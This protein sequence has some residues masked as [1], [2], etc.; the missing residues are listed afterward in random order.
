MRAV[1]VFCEGS[2]DVTFTQRSL[3]AIAQ[4][5]WVS[6]PIRDLPSPFGV[7]TVGRGLIVSQFERVFGDL[8]L[9]SAAYPPLPSFEAIV[10]DP[11]SKTMFML[12]RTNGKDQVDPV[13]NILKYL[14]DIFDDMDIDTY[15]V[16]EYAAAFLFDANAIGRTETI[17]DFRRRYTPHFDNLSGVDHGT[18]VTTDV[19]PVGCFVFHRGIFDQTGTL[20][21]HLAPMAN[22][23]WPDRYARA[24]DF[25]HNN[26]QDSEV[27][28]NGASQ[29]KAVITAAGQF[30]VPGAG[31]TQVIGRGGLSKKVF[32]DSPLS[33]EL[34]DFLM[35]TPWAR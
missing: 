24:R 35:A 13:Q 20:E 6:K 21:D 15:D 23:E 14:Y 4:C 22:A 29:L 19:A 16:T 30:C 33:K 9:Q 17:N 12:I 32:E 1:L 7:S 8:T 28:R 2:H 5:E 26:M 10:E 18:W 34:V 3:G 25:V 31:M 27:S 11:A